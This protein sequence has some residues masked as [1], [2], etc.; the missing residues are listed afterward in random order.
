MSV[1]M[2]ADGRHIFMTE[3]DNHRVSVFEKNRRFVK[4]LGKY[5]MEKRDLC[6]PAGITMDS[7]GY[8]Y[9]CD[10]GNNCIQVF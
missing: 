10:Q 3:F 4:S 8:M 9:I 6:Y 2:G 5:G 7:D 1:C